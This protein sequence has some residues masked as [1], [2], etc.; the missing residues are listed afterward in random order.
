MKAK[1]ESKMVEV[2]AITFGTPM[3]NIDFLCTLFLLLSF[4]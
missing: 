4:Y 2:E 1:I 3:C